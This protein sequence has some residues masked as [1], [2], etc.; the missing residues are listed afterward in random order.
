VIEQLIRANIGTTYAY[1]IVDLLWCWSCGGIARTPM[2]RDG[3]PQEKVRDGRMPCVATTTEGTR[4]SFL[5]KFKEK[6]DSM[7][8]SAKDKVS[9]V[10]GVDTDKLIDTAHSLKE[11]GDS[12]NE[13]ADSFRE[14]RQGHENHS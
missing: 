3:T 1:V 6:A 2:A 7:V 9:D 8:Q 14:G 11:A 13:A 4:M 10:T 12:L 5:D